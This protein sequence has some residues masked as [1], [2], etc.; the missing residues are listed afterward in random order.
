MIGGEGAPEP[1]TEAQNASSNCWPVQP[2]DRDLTLV[3]KFN[4][5]VGMN[6]DCWG[7]EM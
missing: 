7:V 2:K 3:A 4:S 5:T 1:I 6:R